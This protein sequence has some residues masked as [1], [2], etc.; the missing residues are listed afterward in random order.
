MVIFTLFVCCFTWFLGSTLARTAGL[1]G[2]IIVGSG[3]N[4]ELFATWVRVVVQVS[5]TDE[6]KEAGGERNQGGGKT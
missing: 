1:W 3:R 5:K 2:N 6:Y 4:V